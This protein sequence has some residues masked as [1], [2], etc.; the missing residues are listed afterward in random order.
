MAEAVGELAIILGGR[1]WPI[2]VLVLASIPSITTENIPVFLPGV[3][4]ML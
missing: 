2:H 1:P 4:G 3:F